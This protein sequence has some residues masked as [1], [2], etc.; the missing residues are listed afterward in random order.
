MGTELKE[1]LERLLRIESSIEKGIRKEKAKSKVNMQGASTMQMTQAK[2][3]FTGARVV[4]QI[5]SRRV[6]N[7]RSAR[8]TTITQSKYGDDGKYFDL[9]DIEN[10][11]GSWDMY[12]L[13]EGVKYP[14]SQAD[15]FERA[16]F[17]LARREALLGFIALGGGASILVWGAKGSKDAGLPITKGPAP[18][19]PPPP[20]AAEEHS[21]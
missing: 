9:D 6:V 2:S 12:G 20:P 7:R 4:T 5:R 14:V 3:A 1:N 11:S 19:L 15:F 10:T 16:T 13:D 17:G 18:K 8:S 21:S